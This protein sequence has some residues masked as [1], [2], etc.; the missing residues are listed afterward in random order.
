MLIKDLRLPD[1]SFA[2]WKLADDTT[3]SEIVPP[4]KQSAL[5]QAVEFI[6]T[7]SQDNCLQLNPSRCPSKCKEL[8]SFFKRSPPTHPPVELDDLVFER[9][10]SAKVLG[11]TISDDFKSND[12]IFNVTSKAAKR[13]YLLRQ[14]KRV[15]ICASDLVLFY[16]STIRSVLEYTCQVFHFSL[17]SYL[18]EELE[19]I[20]KRALRIIFPY[21]SY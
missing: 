4:S 19:S 20:Q 6:S 8:Q 18:S 5:Q 14:L 11:V 21:A 17:P 12:H 7:W 15:G 10:N 16:C 13:F 3:V 1:G 2:M 9:V